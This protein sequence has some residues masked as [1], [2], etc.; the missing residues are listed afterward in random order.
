MKRG[1]QQV[2]HHQM[3]LPF[4]CMNNSLPASFLLMARLWQLLAEAG[5]DFI[6]SAQFD[7]ALGKTEESENKYFH[8]IIENHSMI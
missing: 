3:S 2:L 6:L 7:F 5:R 4:E 8:G 1:N